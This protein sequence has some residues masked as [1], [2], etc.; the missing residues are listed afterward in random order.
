M[1]IIKKNFCVLLLLKLLAVH[2]HPC[3]LC[4]HFKSPS[5][6]NSSYF[7]SQRVLYSFL[8]H[9]LFLLLYYVQFKADFLSVFFLLT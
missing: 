8:N 5:S 3:I 6:L 1:K 7:P 9:S 2:L 4:G